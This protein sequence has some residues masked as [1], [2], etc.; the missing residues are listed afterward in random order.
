M[1][2]IRDA[3]A[4]TTKQTLRAGQVIQ[5]QHVTV[6]VNT[7][8][9]QLISVLSAIEPGKLNATLDAIAMTLNGRGHEIGEA[10]SD[11][12]RAYGIE[13]PAEPKLP[14]VLGIERFERTMFHSAQWDHDHDLSGERVGAENVG[15][16]T[17]EER[18]NERAPIICSTVEMAQPSD[19]AELEKLEWP[20]GWP[21]PWRNDRL[22]GH[23]QAE[24]TLL[25][26]QGFDSS[27]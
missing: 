3:L 18:I 22:V 11:F 6:E 2:K 14:D 12:L 19:P 4:E 8:F 17:G 24:K 10:F 20:Y 7:V 9:Q 23:D 26:A 16:V 13:V 27:R 25:A 1:P 21:P 5:S 15:L